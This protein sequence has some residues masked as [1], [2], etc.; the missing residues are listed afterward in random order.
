MRLLKKVKK[1]TLRRS[2]WKSKIRRE[3]KNNKG[4][5]KLNLG[6]GN[7]PIK[8]WINVDVYSKNKMFFI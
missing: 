8:G 1:G 3:V 6:A 4:L 2:F 5:L 7:N